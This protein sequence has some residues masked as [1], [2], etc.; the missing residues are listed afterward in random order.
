[1]SLFDIAILITIGG[2]GLFGFWFGFVHTVGSLMGTVLGAYLASRYYKPMA[3]WLIGITGWDENISSVLM[4]IIAFFLINRLVGLVF[5]ILDKALSVITRLPFI[6]SINRFGGLVLGIFEGLLTIGLIFYFIQRFPF[7]EIVMGHV[8]Q[9]WVVPFCI[10]VAVVLLPL[11][12]EGLRL[13]Q[14]SVDQVEAFVL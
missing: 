1:M 12:P 3:E 11:L 2:F 7:S 10:D 6:K 9:S 8:A 4:F 13:L 5:W 14:S